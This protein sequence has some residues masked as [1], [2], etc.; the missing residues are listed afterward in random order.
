M[1][2]L[3]LAESRRSAARCGISVTI[4]QVLPGKLVMYASL[5]AFWPV[6]FGGYWNNSKPENYFQDYIGNNYC[7]C[8][9]AA[10]EKTKQ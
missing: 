4:F 10:G 6:W 8:K 2:S 7:L 3:P 5:V 9:I 1:A